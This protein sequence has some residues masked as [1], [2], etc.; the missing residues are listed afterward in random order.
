MSR[1]IW[2]R[3]T[4]ST[5]TGIIDAETCRLVSDRIIVRELDRVTVHGRS[6][7]SV[8]YELIALAGG[9]TTPAAWVGACEDGLRLY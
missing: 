4:R 3:S 2:K 8:I 5:V 9:S 1:T 7:R 6:A